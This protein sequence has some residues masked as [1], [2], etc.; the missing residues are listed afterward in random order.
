[1]LY[2]HDCGAKRGYMPTIPT[3]LVQNSYQLGKF[4]KHTQP[5][6]SA[7]KTGVYAWPGSNTYTDFTVSAVA[8]GH[9]EIDAGGRWSIVWVASAQTGITWQAGRPVGATDAVRVVCFQDSSTLHSYPVATNDRQVRT[10][11]DCGRLVL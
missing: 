1:M 3:E 10:C 2:C 11:A 4:I 9:V 6:S 8:S 5:S 7:G